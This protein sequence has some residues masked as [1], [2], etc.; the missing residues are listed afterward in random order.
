[1][2]SH[3]TFIYIVP[4]RCRCRRLWELCSCSESNGRAAWTVLGVLL[5]RRRPTITPESLDSKPRTEEKKQT[6]KY[7]HYVYDLDETLGNCACVH[8]KSEC[9]HLVPY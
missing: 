5:R 2:P 1:M 4:S 3:S 9:V 6:T 8:G 7:N